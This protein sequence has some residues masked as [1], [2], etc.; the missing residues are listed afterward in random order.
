MLNVIFFGTPDFSVPSLRLIAQNHH[1]SLVVTSPDKPRRKATDSPEATPVK[2]AAIELGLDVK[3]I[4]EVQ[5]PSF[6]ELL[7]QKKPDVIVVVAFKILPKEIFSIPPKGIFNLH[8]SLLPKFRGAAPINWAIIKGETETGVTTFFLQ[9]KVDTGSMILQRRTEINPDETASELA[10]RLSYLGAETVA[11]T[12]KLI[13][14][15]QVVTTLQ[16]NALATK[17]PKLFKENT[18]INWRLTSEEI[19]NFI[20]GLS[21]HPGAWTTF[22]GKTFRILKSKRSSSETTND[23]FGLWNLT[24]SSFIVNCG[25]GEIEILLL[26]PEGKKEMTA[27]EFLRGYRKKEGERFDITPLPS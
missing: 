7:N 12:L 8:S 14:H 24:S 1:I 22:E 19:H 21:K 6:L 20:R 18:Q 5:D 15:S 23:T 4:E 3:E 27:Q 16:N 17:A 25:V 10:I 26:H 2:K 11:E 9:E 13:E